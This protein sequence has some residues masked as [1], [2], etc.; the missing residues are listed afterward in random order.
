MHEPWSRKPSDPP[1]FASHKAELFRGKLTKQSGHMQEQGTLCILL[2]GEDR[3][4]PGP[5]QGLARAAAQLH[6]S[7]EEPEHSNLQ[8]SKATGSRKG[9]G[10]PLPAHPHTLPAPKAPSTP[11]PAEQAFP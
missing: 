10:L 11:Q 5:K 9:R 2:S 6:D 4:H 8:Q 1:G 3:S 7:P